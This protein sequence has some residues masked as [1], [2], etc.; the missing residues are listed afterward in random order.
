MI[1]GHSYRL[2]LSMAMRHLPDWHLR[3]FHNVA[4]DQGAFPHNVNSY[5][6]LASIIDS[7][8]QHRFDPYMREMNG[9]NDE[10]C[11]LFVDALAECVIFQKTF[12]PDTRPRVPYSTM[13]AHLA[14]FTKLRSFNPNFSTLLEIGPG[15]GYMPFFLRHHAP[16]T[17][18]SQTEACEGYY[19]LQSIVNAHVFGA[20]FQDRAFPQGQDQA[21]A[22]FTTDTAFSDD[23]DHIDLPKGPISIHYPWWRLNEIRENETKFDIIMSNANLK[24]FMAEALDDYL[25][26][27]IDSLADDGILYSQCLGGDLRTENHILQ[28]KL[29]KAGFAP[30]IYLEK[31]GLITIDFPEFHTELKKDFV[32]SSGMFI[33][34]T[35]PL[36]KTYY[37]PK[38][39]MNQFIAGEKPV[40]DL[41][42]GAPGN[43][44]NYTRDEIFQLVT[45]R[46]EQKLETLA[47]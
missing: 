21:A 7:M 9:L 41:F 1:D 17:N 29:Y 23:F 14:A 27:I 16:L 37:E 5:S 6:E 11:D 3:Y 35:H 31:Q 39:Y 2:G 32:V 30:L 15:C 36:F 20:R 47:H 26:L 4:F 24:E 43:R 19:L 28:K 34:K 10:E 25:A 12:M 42:L 46:L 44:K 8:Q 22:T 13:I 18:Y 38:N 40:L 45:K 33:K